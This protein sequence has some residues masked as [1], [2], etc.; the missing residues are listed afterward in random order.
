M[1]N[2]CRISKIPLPCVCPIYVR[3]VCMYVNTVCL[4]YTHIPHICL[5]KYEM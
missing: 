2:S 4:D 3:T 1:T 5:V